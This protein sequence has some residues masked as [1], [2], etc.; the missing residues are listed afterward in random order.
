[1]KKYFI[2]AA[3]CLLCFV[4]G[5]LFTLYTQTPEITG[6]HTVQVNFMGIENNYY[7]DGIQ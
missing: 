5:I 3:L 7:S 1:M 6:D 4:G 2:S